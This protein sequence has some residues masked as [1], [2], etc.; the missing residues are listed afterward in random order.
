MKPIVKQKLST[1]QDIINN[2]QSG[3][4]GGGGTVDAYTK[5]EADAKFETITG[6][7][8]AYL[9]KA[10]AASTYL[11]KSDAASKT[12]KFI[13][14]ANV[15][16]EEGSFLIT[17]YIPFAD[18]DYNDFVGGAIG[19]LDYTGSP[20]TQIFLLHMPSTPGDGT[21]YCISNDDIDF[22]I[23]YNSGYNIRIEISLPDNFLSEGTPVNLKIIV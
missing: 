5:A 7:A 16:N 1:L 11:S 8:A 3:G 20:A 15:I 4:G 17:Y 22:F 14:T 12:N 23:T 9:S 19:I 10:D 13:F 21:A 18:Y 6:A 2:A